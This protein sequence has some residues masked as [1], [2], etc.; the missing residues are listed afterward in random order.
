LL[1][2][3]CQMTLRLSDLRFGFGFG[4]GFEFWFCS[5]CVG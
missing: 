1:A 5:G 4:F 3:L 2:W